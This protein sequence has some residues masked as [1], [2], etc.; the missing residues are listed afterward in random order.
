MAELVAARR[1]LSETEGVRADAARLANGEFRG[2]HAQMFAQ[3]SSELDQEAT[4]AAEGVEALRRAIEGV[5]EEAGRRRRQVEAA[6]AAWDAQA[7]EE[8][9]I[10]REYGNVL[11]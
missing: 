5:V 10:R 9:R 4:A 8:R 11:I 1:L 2:N 3:A 6:Q 7:A